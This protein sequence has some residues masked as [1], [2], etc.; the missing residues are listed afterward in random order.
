MFPVKSLLFLT[1]ITLV[2]IVNGAAMPVEK[3]CKAAGNVC[4]PGGAG[5]A[6]CS[7][8]CLPQGANTAIGTCAASA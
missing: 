1:L 5:E 6:C 8:I 4:N 3:R 2:A 7:N